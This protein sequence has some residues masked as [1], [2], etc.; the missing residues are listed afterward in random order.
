MGTITMRSIY[1]QAETLLAGSVDRLP[2]KLTTIAGA[3][4]PDGDRHRRPRSARYHCAAD[5]NQ[6]PNW[7]QCLPMYEKELA[8]FQE[9][10]IAQL[11]TGAKIEEKENGRTVAAGSFTLK[12]GAGETF[13]V[14]KGANLFAGGTVSITN[15]APELAGM[16]GIRIAPNEGGT[17]QI[18]FGAAGA[19]SCGI[20]GRADRK[21][22]RFSILK[23]NSG[24][25][26][27]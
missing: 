20:R 25:W 18:R 13:T 12:P 3:S 5:M 16:K 21:G 8:T 15:L 19:D 17:L 24:T 6:F 11:S 23:P 1:Q 2:A 14:E 9:A 4:V 26:C 22:I 27:C 10:R 7:Q